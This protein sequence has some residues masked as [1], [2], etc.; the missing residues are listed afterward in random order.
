MTRNETM[1]LTAMS[2]EL[3]FCLD[4]LPGSCLQLI[5]GRWAKPGAQLSGPFIL[6]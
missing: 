1:Q 5:S 2:V 3:S 4:H 6:S